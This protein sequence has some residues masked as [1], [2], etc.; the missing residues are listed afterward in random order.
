MYPWSPPAGHEPSEKTAA[1]TAV[2]RA[3][4]PTSR[5]AKTCLRSFGCPSSETPPPSCA[6]SPGRQPT[7]SPQ[8]QTTNGRPAPPTPHGA[9][10]WPPVDCHPMVHRGRAGRSSGSVRKWTDK[11]NRHGCGRAGACRAG[12]RVE[13]GAALGAFQEVARFRGD[14]AGGMV[15]RRVVQLQAVEADLVQ[16]PGGERRDSARGDPGAAGG[17]STQ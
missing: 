13:G 15:A 9:P 2:L 8:P 17:R 11:I 1:P 10:P 12:R 5:N 7:T 6:S 16:G 3:S 4:P 14:P